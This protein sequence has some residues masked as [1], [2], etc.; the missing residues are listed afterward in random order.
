MT[1]IPRSRSFDFPISPKE[2]YSQI[3]WELTRGQIKRAQEIYERAV[4]NCIWKISE[5]SCSYNT[6]SLS[7]QT[8]AAYQTLSLEAI[9][10]A[11]KKREEGDA[12]KK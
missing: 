8:N 1:S 11:M 10:A 2:C 5:M 4:I 3:Q 7:L 9:E 12:I 6:Y